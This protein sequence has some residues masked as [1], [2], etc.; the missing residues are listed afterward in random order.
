MYQWVMGEWQR[1]WYSM[2]QRQVVVRMLLAPISLAQLASEAS[3]I[4]DGVVQA[5]VPGILARDELTDEPVVFHQATIDVR[6]SL[7]GR[8][9]AQQVVV[10]ALG[11]ETADLSMSVASAPEWHE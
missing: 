6:R 1:W 3:L 11:G 5:V 8:P 2:R 9:P 7:K 4:V 10:R